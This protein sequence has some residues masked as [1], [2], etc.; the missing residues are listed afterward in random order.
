MTLWAIFVDTKTFFGEVITEKDL[1]M[2]KELRD[3]QMKTFP[4]SVFFTAVRADLYAVQRD[5]EK[6]G[7]VFLLSQ[8]GL[9]S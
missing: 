1:E 6:V 2:A 8:S 3:W 4:D 5:T 9:F 7:L